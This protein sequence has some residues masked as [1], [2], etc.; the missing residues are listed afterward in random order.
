MAAP[1]EDSPKVISETMLASLTT[2]PQPEHTFWP[3]SSTMLGAGQLG[4]GQVAVLGWVVGLGCGCGRWMGIGIGCLRLANRSTGGLG[5]G[6]H[7]GGRRV[8]GLTSV[9]SR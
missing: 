6:L 7:G 8:E 5:P 3:S 1:E 9:I 2:V 4:F